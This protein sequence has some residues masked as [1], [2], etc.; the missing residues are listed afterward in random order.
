MFFAPLPPP[1]L[2]TNNDQEPPTGDAARGFESFPSDDQPPHESVR[3]NTLETRTR[4]YA[5]LGDRYHSERTRGEGA[6]AKVYLAR[7]LKHGRDVA[8][9]VL[10]SNVAD[11][12]GGEAFVREM[13]LAATLSH[14]N[15][16]PIFDWGDGDGLLFFAMPNIQGRTLRDEMDVLRQLP[17]DDA[18]RIAREIAGA[19]DHAHRSGVLHRDLRPENLMLEDGRVIVSDFGVGNAFAAIA[20]KGIT[21]AGIS[22]ASPA[23]AS[24]EQV[25]GEAVDARSDVY[26]LASVLYEMLVG[27]APF[28]GPAAQVVVAKRF[29]QTPPSVAAV[30]DGIPRP[31]A[32]ALQSALARSP[33]ERPRTAGAFVESLIE[34]EHESAAGKTEKPFATRE[35]STVS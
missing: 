13:G 1:P 11:A 34:A 3:M 6:L 7:D 27:E 24:P 9:K 19:L 5:A 33:A 26:S 32:C 2:R 23:Y 28:P 22:I 10:T 30:R 14:P 25:A 8:I 16:L 12:I 20:G 31:V 21:R 18:I 15:I 35:T 29:M 17:V 4:L